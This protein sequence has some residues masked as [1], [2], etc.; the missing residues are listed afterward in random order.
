MAPSGHSQAQR[1]GCAPLNSNG[2]AVAG[3]KYGATVKRND[4]GNKR[5]KRSDF[6]WRGQH[7]TALAAKTH[8]RT[9][10]NRQH[11]LTLTAAPTGDAKP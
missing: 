11:L 9:I 7:L 8:C 3:N 2:F 5:Q 4:W 6:A 10:K 1:A